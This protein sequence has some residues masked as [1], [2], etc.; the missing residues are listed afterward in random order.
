MNISDLKLVFFDVLI[1]QALPL[2]L[3]LTIASFFYASFIGLFLGIIRSFRIPF[4]DGI[5]GFYAQ[6]AR[7]V[8]EMLI[9]LFLYAYL[10]NGSVFSISVL[11]IS[12]VQGAYIMEIIKGSLLSVDRGQWDA[13]HALSLGTLT[14][15][16][17]II[18]PQILLT[19]LPALIGQF[20]LL[21]KS[22]SVASTIGCLEL[23][24]RAQLV[25][26][27]YPYP[28]EIYG[29]VLVIFFLICHSITMI[30]NKFEKN[31]A[32]RIMGRN[33]ERTNPQ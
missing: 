7:A 29:M 24:R 20:V 31:V 32:I 25:L 1:K 33:D 17:R 26:P 3:Q 21:I 23:T 16:L 19:A 27:R 11:A 9:L 4:I 2:T 22:T 12:L 28:L 6:I 15:L 14:T 10:T 8:P 5:L 18:I 13:A 30:G